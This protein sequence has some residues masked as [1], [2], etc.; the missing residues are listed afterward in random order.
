[1]DVPASETYVRIREAELRAKCRALDH[2]LV[3]GP[4]AVGALGLDLHIVALSE[5]RDTVDD[6][7]VEDVGDARPVSL[8]CVLLVVPAAGR[9]VE[10]AG[11]APGDVSSRRSPQ[12][13]QV[14]LL[15]TIPGSLTCSPS[16]ADG[17]TY[18]FPG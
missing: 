5:P 7:V 3:L 12:C 11:F 4:L 6:Y 15:R 2:V 18:L 1:V 9:A 16:I 17:T 14:T 8:T 13:G 10:G